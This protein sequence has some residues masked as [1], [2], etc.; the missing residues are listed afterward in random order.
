MYCSTW[1]IQMKITLVPSVML[2]NKLVLGK[3]GGEDNR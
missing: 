1:S 3:I 2:M